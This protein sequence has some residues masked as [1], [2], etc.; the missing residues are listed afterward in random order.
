MKTTLAAALAA[1]ALSACAPV[2]Q[3]VDPA[4]GQSGINLR[5]DILAETDVAGMGYLITP[6]DCETGDVVG[7]P[8][9]AQRDLEDLLL[10]GG[11]PG[12]ENQPF[13]AASGHLFADHF[14]ALEPG[15]Y[16]VTVQPVTADG[17]ASE[18]CSPASAP[19]VEVVAEQ[20][21][22]IMLISQCVGDEIGALD[23]IAAINH[24]PEITH[25][26]Y[27]PSKF[28]CGDRTTI[29]VTSRDPDGDPTVLVADA[30]DGVELVLQRP[31]RGEDGATTQCVQVSVP[32]PGEYA[33]SLSVFDQMFGAE[34][35]LVTVESL[36]DEGLTSHASIT[37]PVHA[38]EA[39][40]CLC[41]CPEG[42]SLNA[43]GD[44]CE[45]QVE[46]DA[47]LKGAVVVVC[48]GVDRY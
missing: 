33:V 5:S 18:H 17:T 11:H 46:V 40:A 23:I 10:P 30:E 13:D 43:A 37:A 7:E 36:L 42:F 48:D 39:E 44:A 14:Q 32:A 9:D 26:A 12:F 22:E 8:V 38:M 4:V 41:A 29:C 2:D 16:D 45:R 27:E 47:V 19:A 24:A 15:C 6:V 28:T 21:T 35:R 20:V 3:P 25:I 1:C 31:E 34:G